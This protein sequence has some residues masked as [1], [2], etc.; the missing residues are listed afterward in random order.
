MTR[1]GMEVLRVSTNMSLRILYQ[2]IELL[3]ILSR[4]INQLRPGENWIEAIWKGG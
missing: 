2:I 3:E 4:E 1:K